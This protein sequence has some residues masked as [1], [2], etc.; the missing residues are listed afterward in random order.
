MAK[1]PLHSCM[2]DD[3]HKQQNH[4]NNT[5]IFNL[6]S[7]QTTNYKKATKFNIITEIQLHCIGPKFF[8]CNGIKLTLAYSLTYYRL[9]CA[10]EHLIIMI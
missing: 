8:N 3:Q 9:L 5:Q 4:K 6:K 1:L 7:W 2:N 10:V